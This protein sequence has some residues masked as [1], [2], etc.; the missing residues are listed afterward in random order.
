MGN[1][2]AS[3]GHEVIHWS[4]GEHRSQALENQIIRINDEQLKVGIPA[5]KNAA[6]ALGKS[7]DQGRVR[8]SKL[9]VILGLK[10]KVHP[11]QR[12]PGPALALVI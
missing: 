2:A 6:K 7:P 10:S 9:Q 5:L 8:G 1:C 3:L 12:E 11:S 4:F